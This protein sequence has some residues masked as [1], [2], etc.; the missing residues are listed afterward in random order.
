MKQ[1]GFTII[2]LLV[3]IVVLVVIT[4][5]FWVQFQ[6]AQ[7]MSRDDKRRTAI[8]AMFYNLEDV[9]YI[10]NGYYPSTVSEKILT[11]M[12]ASL[13]KDPNGN[14]IGTSDSDYQY[15]PKNCTGEKC[16]SYT[17]RSNMERE[18]DFVK[19]SLH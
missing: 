17:V 11:A 3:A 8:N 2:E 5:V 6:N 7:S 4:T 12:D 19:S 15:L 16:T 1:R 18:A 10:K 14:V 13:L 9:F